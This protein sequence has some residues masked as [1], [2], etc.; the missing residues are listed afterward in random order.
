M[1]SIVSL[2]SGRGSRLGSADLE[3]RSV[4]DRKDLV[5]FELGL[6]AHA[7]RL[8]GRL[9]ECLTDDRRRDRESLL[10]EWQPRDYLYGEPLGDATLLTTARCEE[11][12][13]AEDAGRGVP[14]GGDP[15]LR[16]ALRL[17]IEEIGARVGA[18]GLC[19]RLS[20]RSEVR[21]N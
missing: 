1:A 11:E 12:S 14:E 20:V 10:A 21:C 18:A 3:R 4:V 13:G 16:Q 9:N 6:L 5:A 2:R 7:R 15:L 8:E 17:G 19:G